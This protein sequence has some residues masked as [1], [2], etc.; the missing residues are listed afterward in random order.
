M[1]VICHRPFLSYPKTA[2]NCHFYSPCSAHGT[3]QNRCY[4]FRAI[5]FP[6]WGPHTR[7]KLLLLD[8]G[9]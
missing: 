8:E 9:K 6:A 4:R 5:P 2:E 1:T 7:A 3:Q